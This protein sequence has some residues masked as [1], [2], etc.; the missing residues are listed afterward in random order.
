MSMMLLEK[1]CNLI[2]MVL[3]QPRVKIGSIYREK[4]TNDLYFLQQVYVEYMDNYLY[5][6]LILY[7]D[8]KKGVLPLHTKKIKL[9]CLNNNYELTS[10]KDAKYVDK[11]FKEEYNRLMAHIQLRKR[12][13]F[14]SIVKFTQGS[15]GVV[16]EENGNFITIAFIYDN[17]KD[18]VEQLQEMVLTSRLNLRTYDLCFII[19]K[20]LR[21]V[22]EC[23]NKENLRTFITKLRLSGVIS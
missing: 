22:R 11:D 9:M 20:D 12:V 3:Y 16:I 2:D 6:Y 7:E 21:Y 23:K 10:K 15:Y 1:D 18:I 5:A 4:E 14:G 8:L 19:D 13:Q 17:E